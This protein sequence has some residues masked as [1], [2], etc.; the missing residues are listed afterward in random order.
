MNNLFRLIQNDQDL[1][2]DLKMIGIGQGD[3]DKRV[4]GWRKKFRV[5]FPLFSDREKAVFKKFG[6]P[7]TPYT[8]LVD[9]NGKVLYAHGGEIQDIEEFFTELK[10]FQKSN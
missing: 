1:N 5:K 4:D 9:P 3:S 6:S 10:K 7:G 2:N 8:V